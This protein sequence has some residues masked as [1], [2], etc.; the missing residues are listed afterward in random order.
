MNK[1]KSLL[2]LIILALILSQCERE[3]K[4]KITDKVFLKTLIE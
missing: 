1:L 3:D 2:L 4:V